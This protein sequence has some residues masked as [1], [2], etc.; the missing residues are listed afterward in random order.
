M[1]NANCCCYL[2]TPIVI[3]NTDSL[4]R[5]HVSR[6]EYYLIFQSKLD[7]PDMS[8]ALA[9]CVSAVEEVTAGVAN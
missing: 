6:L 4:K 1:A 2:I 3:W 8:S 7:V 5:L 9:P